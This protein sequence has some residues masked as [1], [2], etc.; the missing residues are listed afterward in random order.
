M[1][2]A[3]K[4]AKSEY[5][6]GKF[7]G[8]FRLLRPKTGAAGTSVRGFRGVKRSLK[9][10]W[11]GLAILGVALGAAGS[12]FLRANKPELVEKIEKA[13]KQLV[14]R[15]CQPKQDKTKS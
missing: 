15:F 8:I 6:A 12:E 14:D 2:P 5:Q 4:Y 11:F 7:T 13:A 3:G 9:M 10:G 1:Q